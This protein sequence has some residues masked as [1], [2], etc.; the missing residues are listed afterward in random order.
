M[1]VDRLLLSQR[2]GT[3]H[4]ME[5][6]GQ[7]TDGVERTAEGGRWLLPLLLAIVVA[8]MALVA[9]RGGD[10]G[11][12]GGG[13]VADQS[14]SPLPTGIT[15]S[16]EIDFGN[17]AV[18]RF[19]ALPWRDEMTVAQVMQVAREFSPGI[20]FQQVGEGATGLL[21]AIDGV[22]NQGAGGRNWRIEVD[23]KWLEVSFCLE[24]VAPG[25][26]VLWTFAGEE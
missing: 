4:S 15:V 24:K 18:K 8:G 7:S 23:G 26:R 25:A 21:T 13:R 22:A 16:L 12:R 10:V 20:E 1:A 6:D 11:G 14:P 9:I 19:A 3:L 17:G 2:R 5:T